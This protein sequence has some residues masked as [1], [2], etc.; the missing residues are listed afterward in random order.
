MIS[1]R[2]FL[3][4]LTIS[5]IVGVLPFSHGFESEFQIGI[6]DFVIHG[7]MKPEVAKVVVQAMAD[8]FAVPGR[9]KPDFQFGSPVNLA[10]QLRRQKIHLAIMTGIEYA[11]IGQAFPELR[12]LVT[13]FTSDI[14]LKACI[15]APVESSAKTIFDLKGQSIVLPKRLQH[16]PLLYLQQ[17]IVE[18]GAEPKSFFSRIVMANDTD[19]G[20]ELVVDKKDSAILIDSE[21]WR[22]YQERKPGRARK[23]KVIDEWVLHKRMFRKCLNHSFAQSNQRRN[24]GKG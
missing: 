2:A 9:P 24:I 5:S 14:R 13:A 1:R 22:V 18:Q 23:L 3:N 19:E 10:N 4:G 7:Q 12:P 17:E 20:V 8:I 6:A 11:W 21:S 16:F 15:L